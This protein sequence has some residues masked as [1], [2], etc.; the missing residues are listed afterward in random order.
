VEAAWSREIVR[1]VAELDA[2][3]VQTIPWEEV[4]EELFG[5]R[6]ER[7]DSATSERMIE[8]YDA[9]SVCAQRLVQLGDAP[10]RAKAVFL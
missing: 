10:E 7:L 3:T 9:R 8:L 4:R 5:R 1:R 6:D 2:G